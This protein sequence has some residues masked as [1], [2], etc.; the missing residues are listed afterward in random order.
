MPGVL[1]LLV[2]NSKHLYLRPSFTGHAIMRQWIEEIALRLIATTP[3]TLVRLSLF[4]PLGLG[5][6]FAN[7]LRLDEKI[8]GKMAWHKTKDIGEMLE[9]I[10]S[11]ISTMI[12]HYLR[13]EYANIEEYNRIGSAISEPYHL[14]LISDFPSGFDAKSIRALASIAQ[15]GP[16][17]G[18]YI[19]MTWLKNTSQKIEEHAQNMLREQAVEILEK[20]PNSFILS[21]SALNG[22]LLIPDPM[23]NSAVINRI[24]E[25]INLATQL[26]EQI[27]VP[28]KKL[29]P[30]KIWKNSTT[31]ALSI[32]IGQTGTEIHYLEF[33]RGTAHHAL[34]GGITGSGKSVLL[35]TIILAASLHFSPAEL[36]LYLIDFKEGVEFV[37]Y[38]NLPHVKVVAIQ[39]DRE[40]GISVLQGLAEELNKRG[41]LFRARGSSDIKA[42]RMICSDPMPRIL[43]VIDEFQVFFDR[44]D[45]LA[46]NARKLIDTIA[47]QGRS[48]GVHLVLAS[49]TLLSV[50]L[51]PGTL[52][53][54]G[55]RIALRMSEQDAARVLSRDNNAPQYLERPGEAI[56]NSQAGNIGANQH[57]QV[58]YLS[59]KERLN[60]INIL[61]KK[62]DQ[63]GF[64]EKT[65]IFEGGRLADFTHVKN[66]LSNFKNASKSIRL[67]FGK[68]MR[69]EQSH[70]HVDLHRQSRANILLV[71]L[72]EKV[73]ATTL[74]A[75]LLSAEMTQTELCMIDLTVEGSTAYH[76]L[77]PPKN[78]KTWLKQDLKSFLTTANKELD[79]RIAGE[80]RKNMLLVFWGIHATAALRKDGYRPSELATILV[81]LLQSGP[82]HGIH[83]IAWSSTMARLSEILENKKI[84]DFGVKIALAGGD[85]NSLLPMTQR[86]IEISSE[87]GWLV[88]EG[89]NRA[90]RF[91]SYDPE[92]FVQKI[93]KQKQKISLV[94]IRPLP[95]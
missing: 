86:N 8:R 16:R 60:Q 3:P 63:E 44:N 85:S 72:A 79:E 9:E 10:T 29:V 55:V 17:V 13:N 1:P 2:E 59:T 71:G 38:R 47:R 22:V 57:L 11:Q 46:Q 45:K 66:A 49:Q 64:N 62:A 61:R 68:P 94:K 36:Q 4:D 95:I 35:H 26:A 51:D 42:F 76:L 87:D 7:L 83:L 77:R 81:R 40:F 18:V 56:Y 78:A 48:F 80:K 92:T 67:Y 28:F 91:R 89:H 75:A 31:S 93:I 39:S 5:Q 84:Q 27:V 90:S 43:V 33:G 52:P 74:Q 23:P 15:N 65:I 6:S 82:E 34:I 37:P 12:Q 69:V 25:Q 88:Q 70:V 58:A 30:K 41:S 32:P 54:L 24:T 19:I 14:L 20:E 53:Q 73:A 50:Q 21:H